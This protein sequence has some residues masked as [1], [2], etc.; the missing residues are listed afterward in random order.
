MQMITTEQNERTK[1]LDGLKK[2]LTKKFGT[3]INEVS[4]ECD[5]LITLLESVKENTQ[6]AKH[7]IATMQP[8]VQTLIQ[9]NN[10]TK[11]LLKTKI[12]PILGI[13]KEEITQLKKIEDVCKDSSEDSSDFHR[14]HNDINQLL[15]QSN[16][17]FKKK[18]QTQKLWW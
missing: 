5:E 6:E 3:R 7:A 9:N 8:A 2:E 15:H 16:E 11:E 10:Q 17:T 4:H 1:A 18:Q 12:V 14:M 13:I